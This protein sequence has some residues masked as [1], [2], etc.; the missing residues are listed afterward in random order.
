MVCYA[1]GF[2]INDSLKKKKKPK[3]IYFNA[4]VIVAK[5]TSGDK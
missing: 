4:H 1:A 5:K 3:N 2:G